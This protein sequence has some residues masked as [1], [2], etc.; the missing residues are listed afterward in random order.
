MT[1]DKKTKALKDA[2]ISKAT[3]VMKSPEALKKYIEKM[4]SLKDG[5]FIQVSLI[6]VLKDANRLVKIL[7]AEDNLINLVT[8]LLSILERN[9]GS[10]FEKRIQDLTGGDMLKFSIG[11]RDV[12]LSQEDKIGTVL[13]SIFN[14]VLF[15]MRG[16]GAKA[17]SNVIMGAEAIDLLLNM[18][19]K[20]FEEM[21]TKFAEETELPDEIRKEMNNVFEEMNN[22]K[23]EKYEA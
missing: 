23:G 19:D 17:I 16:D 3:E 7:K 5:E 9:S 14:D 22:S 15:G 10:L 11:G 8:A 12:E 2:L 6:R 13:K 21:A 18:D 20:E 1:K 4:D